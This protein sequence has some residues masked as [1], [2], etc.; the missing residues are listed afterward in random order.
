M[1]CATGSWRSTSV[2]TAPAGRRGGQWLRFVLHD[3]PVLVR[4]EA[5]L[6]WAAAA[7]FFLPLFLALYT[8]QFYPDGVYFLLTPETVGSAEEMYA[9]AVERLG[10]P[11]EASDDVMMLGFYIGNKEYSH[12]Q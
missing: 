6:V 9:P 12:A 1:P 10:R 4:S 3:F 5:R 7:L 8:L 11:R 2:F